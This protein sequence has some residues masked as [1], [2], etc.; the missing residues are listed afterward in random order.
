MISELNLNAFFMSF[1]AILVALDAPGILPIFI[2]ITQGIK[3]EERKR[4]VRQSILTAFLITIGFIFLGSVIF[5]ALVITVEDF[6]IAGGIV[7]L[8]I[9]VSDIILAGAKQYTISPTFGIVPLGTPLIAG[10]ATLTTTLALVSSYGYVPVLFS[11]LANILLAWLILSQSDRIIRLIGI[12]G[13]LAFAKV[14]AL[15]LAA[16]AVKMIRT[17]LFKILHP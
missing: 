14:A 3:T 13:S 6:M 1:I 2:S 5:R 8:I 12:N 7:L 10:P 4:I 16:I 11:L 17:G 9:A 15:L